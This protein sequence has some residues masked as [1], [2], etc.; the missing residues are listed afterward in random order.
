MFSLNCFMSKFLFF[1]KIFYLMGS[2]FRFIC[3]FLGFLGSCLF[4]IYMIEIVGIFCRGYSYLWGESYLQYFGVYQV[5]GSV[6]WFLLVV[7]LCQRLI[8]SEEKII[9]VVWKFLLGVM[10][11]CDL[12]VQ[13]LVRIQGV[14]L[15]EILQFLYR[16]RFESF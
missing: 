6:F 13:V 3:S 8:G 7:G 10:L 16:L 11:E 15:Q 12:V 4:S 5:G 2:Y 14:G 9:W 1:N